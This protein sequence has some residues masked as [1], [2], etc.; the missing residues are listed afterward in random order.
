M[1]KT[2]LAPLAVA[3]AVACGSDPNAQISGEWDWSATFTS[4]VLGVTCV[5]AGSLLL[6]QSSGGSTVSGLRSNTD[7][8]CEGGP[9]NLEEAL[10]QPAQVIN[11]EVNGTSITMEIDFCDFDGTIMLDTPAGDVMSGTLVC[12]EGIPLQPEVFTGTW[13]ASR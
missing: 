2:Y 9:D 1:N 12:Q 13:E 10:G 7:V 4:E 6:S 11:S 8:A 5:T 3:L